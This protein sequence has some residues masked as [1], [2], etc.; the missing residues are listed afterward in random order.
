MSFDWDEEKA[1]ENLEKHGVS[2]GEAQTVFDDPLYVDF[3]DPEHSHEEHRYIILGESRQGRLLLVS[4][5]ER[6]GVIRLISS[7]ETTPAERRD[8]EES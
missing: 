7:R 6:G 1:G 2:F 4:Y 3:Y 5:T 8:Y